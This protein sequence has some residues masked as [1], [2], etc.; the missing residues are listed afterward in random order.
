MDSIKHMENQLALDIDFILNRRHVSRKM[1]AKIMAIILPRITVFS[2]RALEHGVNRPGITGH[3]MRKSIRQD[4]SIYAK[5]YLTELS[6]KTKPNINC[7]C[8]EGFICEDCSS[9]TLEKKE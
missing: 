3:A 4:L 9:K 8:W 5:S 1:S 2:H 6:K 7:K